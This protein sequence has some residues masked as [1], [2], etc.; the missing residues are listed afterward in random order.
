[1]NN[2]MAF[3]IV[4]VYFTTA[5]YVYNSLCILLFTIIWLPTVNQPIGNNMLIF[6][7]KNVT[8]HNDLEEIS[9]INAAT[10]CL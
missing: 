7:S 1:M 5:K 10:L 4:A 9:C 6:S 3:E 8:V 2:S